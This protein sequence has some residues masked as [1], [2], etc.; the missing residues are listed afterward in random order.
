M[1]EETTI[2]P[3]SPGSEEMPRRQSAL[4]CH[5]PLSGN[6]GELRSNTAIAAPDSNWA[7]RLTCFVF[8]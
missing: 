1:P 3:T 5:P 2:L 6:C 8:S 7:K 4:A